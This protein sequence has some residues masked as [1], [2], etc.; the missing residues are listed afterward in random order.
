MSFPADTGLAD[1]RAWRYAD[2]ACARCGVVVAVAKLS[3]EH[4]SVQWPGEAVRGCAEFAAKV[5]AGRDSALIPTCASLRDSIDD[6]V[7]RGRVRVGLGGEESP[8]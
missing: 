1:E 3:P 4:T 2:V 7:A 5:A 6:A 8:P